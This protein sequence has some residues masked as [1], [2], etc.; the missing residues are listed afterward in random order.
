MSEMVQIEGSSAEHEFDLDLDSPPSQ[1]TKKQENL[2][3]T[4]PLIF[5]VMQHSVTVF[6]EL[7][8]TEKA[9]HRLRTF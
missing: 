4:A 3:K 5:S 2:P 9:R 6:Y 8:V 7:T 1:K